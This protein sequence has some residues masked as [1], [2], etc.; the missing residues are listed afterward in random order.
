MQF[1]QRF[2]III[3]KGRNG[4]D[5]THHRFKI[6]RTEPGIQSIACKT[7]QVIDQMT[8]SYEGGRITG[9]DRFRLQLMKGLEPGDPNANFSKL[10]GSPLLF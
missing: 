3:G 5:N 6:I 1:R 9:Q 7:I 8:K 2:Q 4:A 10:Q